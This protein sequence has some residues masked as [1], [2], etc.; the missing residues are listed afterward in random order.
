LAGN[1]AKLTLSSPGASGSLGASKAIVIDTIAPTVL[2]INPSKEGLIIPSDNISIIFSESIDG[3]SIINSDNNSCNGNIKI[4][5]DNFASCIATNSS[6]VNETITIDPITNFDFCEIYEVK[7]TNDIK[8]FAGNSL[9]SNNNVPNDN[10]SI[11]ESNF[12]VYIPNMYLLGG[13]NGQ[14]YSSSTGVDSWTEVTT[15]NS[16]SLKDINCGKSIIII[17][18]GG[19]PPKNI[20][21]SFDNGTTW[22]NNT[23][24]V[25]GTLNAVHYGYQTFVAVG[26]SGVLTISSDDNASTW[27]SINDTDWAPSGTNPDLKG[28]VSGNNVFVAVGTSGTIIISP[29]NASSW[30]SRSSERLNH[31]PLTTD[32]SYWDVT[33]GN[34]KFI[35]VGD[36]G[37]IVV[38]SDNGSSWSDV[39]SGV[40]ALLNAVHFNNG[41][42]IAGGRTG[43]LIT[44]SDNGTSWT[45]RSSGT[46]LHL[47]DLTSDYSGAIFGTYSHPGIN[48][49]SSDNGTSWSSSAV[50]LELHWRTLSAGKIK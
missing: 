35:A 1:N 50:P 11:V 15:G 4:S 27:T 46:S 6:V 22:D 25:G 34:N 45:S 49:K 30:T 9:I 43:T 39:T 29:D 31:A 26:E 12:E 18:A 48:I 16:D 2:S 24:N 41:V 14:M 36:S 20:L 10:V 32:K 8:D 19:G 28:V 37:K 38:S 3:S 33:F 42:F 23:S 13:D 7:I 5:S 17:A 40:S 47:N 21:T 44:S